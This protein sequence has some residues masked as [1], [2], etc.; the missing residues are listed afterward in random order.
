MNERIK[1]L[2]RQ[3]GAYQKDDDGQE[4]KIAIL[5]GNEVE[6]FAEMI[7]D[8]CCLKLVDMHEG[9]KGNHNFYMHAALEM[10]R[11]FRGKS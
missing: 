11:H 10:K 2:A 5:I 9:T 6:K 7:V 4:T 8:E 3:C 1:K